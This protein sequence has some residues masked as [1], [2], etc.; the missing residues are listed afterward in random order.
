MCVPNCFLV[1]DNVNH[2]IYNVSLLAAAAEKF[3]VL[4][5]TL[6]GVNLSFSVVADI[7]LFL[8]SLAL[9]LFSDFGKSVLTRMWF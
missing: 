6:N 2:L 4:N 7:N 1:S 5:V 9:I 8:L 3:S